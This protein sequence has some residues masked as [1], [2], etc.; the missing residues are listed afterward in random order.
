MAVN[1]IISFD[2]SDNDHDALAL[3]RVLASGGASVS[4][5]YVR[6]AHEA[7][8]GREQSA[9][10][11]ADAILERG[12]SWLGT[13]VERHVVV[14]AST[15]EG[16]RQLAEE[17][18][19]DVV[20][21]GSDWHTT[22]GHVQPGTSA[23]R[24]MDGGPVAIA[25]AAAGLRERKDARIEHVAL[26]GGEVDSAARETAEALAGGA[27]LA[28]PTQ[29]NVDLLVVGSRPGAPEGRVGLSAAAEYLVETT[30]ASVL[31]LARGVAFGAKQGAKSAGKTAKA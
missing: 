29:E 25:I 10:A 17:Q 30:N 22:P 14:N 7:D 9:Q 4:L 18:G 5:A 11:D 19:A 31:V 1:M 16:L 2:G 3:G 26:P 27:P 12:A 28:L 24:L 21:F 6:H 15:G 8:A 20:V 23:L 13:D